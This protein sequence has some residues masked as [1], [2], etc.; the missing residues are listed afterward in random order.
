[1][2]PKEG[3]HFYI[4]GLALGIVAR[5]TTL[6]T[7]AYFYLFDEQPTPAQLAALDPNRFDLCCR[8]G[9]C[10][11]APYGNWQLLGPLPGFDR[12]RWPMP[13]FPHQDIISRRW[14][15]RFY[16]DEGAY[17]G[18]TPISDEE[19]VRL[20]RGGR[21]RSGQVG[22]RVVVANLIKLKR[23]ETLL[24]G[25]PLPPAAHAGA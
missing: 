17:A 8:I 16:T 20:S 25:A 6:A 1:M 13:A 24:V 11:F 7:L 10:G 5:S 22:D 4:P 18:E 3:E 19:G 9:L 12:S 2:R 23:G 21:L 15:L 14:S